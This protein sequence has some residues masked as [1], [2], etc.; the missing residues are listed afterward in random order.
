MLRKQPPNLGIFMGSMA[1]LAAA[2]AAALVYF[3]RQ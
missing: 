3:I 1:V 2:L